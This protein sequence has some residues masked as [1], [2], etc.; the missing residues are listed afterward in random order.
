[1]PRDKTLAWCREQA[2]L[3]E[4][5]A[6]VAALSGGPDS[7]AMLSLLL[8][9]RGELGLTVRAAH[10]NHHLRGADSDADEDFCR[11]LCGQLGVPLVCGGG[12]AAASARETGQSLETA[13]RQLR[14]GFLLSQDGL[15]ATA[16]TAND[17]LETVLLNLTRGTALRGLGG[18]PPKRGRVIRPLLCL[19]R[20][21]I[22]AYL[23]ENG[24]P[25]VTDE[26]NAQGFCRR[27]RLRQTAVPALLRENPALLRNLPHTLAA[28]REDEALL[29]EQAASLLAAAARGGGWEVEALAA[30]PRPLRR[31]ALRTILED[32]GLR[33]AT[34]AHLERVETLLHSGPS[35]RAVL[36]GGLVLRRVYGLLLAGA[37]AERPF[38]P[39][40]LPM[41]GSAALS[42]G[43][44]LLCQGP[45]PYDG[46]SR[47]FL[48][49]LS[50]APLVR[51]RR[52]G[53]HLRLPGGGKSVK[54][55]MIDRKLPA[56]AR[57]ALPVF[58]L[59]GA[60][61]AVWGVGVD[62]AYRPAPG[63]LCYQL[64]ILEPEVDQLDAPKR[65][66]AGH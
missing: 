39:F 17:N 34:L 7:V 35:A 27:N 65:H 21:E 61:I 59:R 40:P 1:M 20:R 49:R 12:D 18:I 26:T 10:Y 31:R 64:E 54:K 6:V 4:G 44:T 29:Q 30:A 13:A 25:F 28:L 46:V 9:L 32:A 2:L 42:G 38:E 11:A 5:A 52:P 53:D 43:R 23:A 33:D 3:P 45:L 60:V 15:I 62:P 50:E 37:P 48:L 24:L 66:D 41:P 16:H 51:T 56:G 63:E 57:D 58:E 47:S 14:Y 22:E 8:S 19:T 36:P 55:W